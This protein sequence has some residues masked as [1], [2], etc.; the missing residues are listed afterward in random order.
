MDESFSTRPVAGR[1]M[2][3]DFRP[4]RPLTILGPAWAALCGAIASGGLSWR[5][6]SVLFFILSF[7]LC[8]ALLGAWRAL[9]FGSE[10]RAALTRASTRTQTWQDYDAPSG[11]W[12]RLRWQIKRRIDFLRRVIWPLIDSETIGMFF[13]GVLGLSLAAVLGVAPFALTVVAMVLALLEGRLGSARGAGLRAITEVAIPWLIAQS[14]FASFSFWALAAALLF[15]LVYRAM[16]GLALGQGQWTRWS[17]LLQVGAILMLVW[18]N[19]PLGAGIV[20]LGLIAQLLWQVRYRMDRDGRAYVQHVQ[21]YILVA[22]LVM[23]FS[24][25]F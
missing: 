24:L 9:W 4:T 25:W 10:L 18:S 6:Q 16:I 3:L 22:M 1:W 5:G 23:A 14:A 8:D 12:A 13:A 20:A 15:T 2:A 11:R 7:L 19:T 21:S 17:N